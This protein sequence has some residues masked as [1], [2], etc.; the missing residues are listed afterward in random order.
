MKLWLIRHGLTRL[1]E[2]KR[3]QG[4]LDEPLSER[5]RAEL[6]RADFAPAHVYVSPM[7]RARETAA[8]LFPIVCCFRHPLGEHFFI[9]YLIVLLAAAF[10]FVGKFRLPK[11]KLKVMVPIVI[12]AIVIFLVLLI[13]GVFT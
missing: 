4:V 5:G 3:Y 6:R 2:E 9:L 7:R 12:A 8:I 1:G 13:C 11:L 10:A